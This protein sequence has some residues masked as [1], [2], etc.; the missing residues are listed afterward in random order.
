M[1]RALFIAAI[2][3]LF[4]T[5]ASAQ[6]LD[7]IEQGK[8]VYAAQKCQTCHSIHGVGNKRGA[9][10][11]VG[12][13]LSEDEIRSWIV[14]APEMMAKTKATRKPVMK[15]YPLSKDDLEALV[16]YLD[17]LKAKS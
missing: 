5:L 11:D 1:M 17:S 7:T 14:S 9:L 13:R 4:T 6:S 2:L 12:T 15:S 16:T 3:G 8:K 10:D